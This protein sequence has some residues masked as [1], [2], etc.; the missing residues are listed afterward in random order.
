MKSALLLLYCGLK[1]KI[2]GGEIAGTAVLWYR[3][4]RE[5]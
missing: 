5:W 3:D 4:S 2:E 1:N